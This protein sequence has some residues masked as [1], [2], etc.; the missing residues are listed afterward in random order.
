MSIHNLHASRLNSTTSSRE[1]EEI[2]VVAIGGGTG[3]PVL[4][5]GL[6]QFTSHITAIVTVA[7]DGGSSGRL[8]KSMGILPPGDF[9]NNIAALSESEDIFQLLLQYRF[10]RREGLEGH[11]LGNLLITAMAS[12][13][14]N[15][16]SGIANTSRV[17]AVKGQVL[18]STLEAVTLC[19]EALSLSAE[20][21]P[22]YALLRGEST[23][24]DAP[25]RILRVMLDPPDV[26][27]YPVAV[28]AILRSDLIVAGPG[29]FFTSTM[30]SLLIR[31]IRQAVEA[32]PAPKVF[33]ANILNQ[34]GET[35]GFTLKNYLEELSR[36]QLHGFRHVLV[37][38]RTLTEGGWGQLEWITRNPGADYDPFILHE[39]N[40]IDEQ[41]SWRHDS[42]KLAACVWKLRLDLEREMQE[43]R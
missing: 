4:L 5:R 3:L 11:A 17:L 1:D 24:G 20:E 36:H 37:N 27:A 23:I 40:L 43:E 34:T 42:A 35:S 38:S 31:G 21:T 13:F 22:S 26:K 14:G 12:I 2:R 32:S 30:P 8:Q 25:E 9:R 6:K 39:S 18:P 41:V 28:Q 7:D 15:F 10:G 19:A 29:S 16:E 33:V